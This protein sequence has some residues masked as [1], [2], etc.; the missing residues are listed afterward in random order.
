MCANMLQYDRTFLPGNEKMI[1]VQLLRN[2][3]VTAK[4][5]F[6][7]VKNLVNN[8]RILGYQ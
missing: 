6:N 4:L 1:L 3:N 5:L 8:I 2:L 7:L